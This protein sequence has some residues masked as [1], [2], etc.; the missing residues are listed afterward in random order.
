M[1]RKLYDWIVALSARPSA[2]WALAAVAF[3]ESSFFI[4]PPDVMLAPMALARPERAFRYAFICTLGSVAGGIL[5]YAIGH[6]LF[7]SVGMWILDLY[8]YGAKV[9]VVKEAY[10]KWGAMLILLKGLTPIPFKLV[11]IVSGALDYNF[12]LFVILSFI[13]RGARFFLLAGLLNR[14]G[15][16]MRN[17][18]E[19]RLGLVV[20]GMVALFVLG[21]IVAAKL[22]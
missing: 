10:A 20:S 7:D 3:A 4:I 17:F 18:I 2:P 19:N 9:E 6:L 11:T 15:G 1:L 13:T 22:A 8:G 16:P 14:F 12:P 21:L 5:G